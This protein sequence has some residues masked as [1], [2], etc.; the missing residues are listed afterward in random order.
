MLPCC[1]ATQ[2]HERCMHFGHGVLRDACYKMIHLVCAGPARKLHRKETSMSRCR[3]APLL[4]I[5]ALMIGFGWPQQGL[6]QTKV[7][8]QSI[9]PFGQEVKLAPKTI[10]YIAG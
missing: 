10:V 5:A 8:T 3:L 2:P 1:P 9:D 4:A 6:A 7:P